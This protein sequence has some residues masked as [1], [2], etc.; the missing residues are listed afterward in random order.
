VKLIA[1]LLIVVVEAN[2]RCKQL[3]DTL[4]SVFLQLNAFVLFAAL[5]QIML[6]VDGMEGVIK[7]QETVRWLYSLI[8]SKVSRLFLAK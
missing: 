3:Y 1:S 7:H 4:A 5:G 6:Y 8:A 2:D